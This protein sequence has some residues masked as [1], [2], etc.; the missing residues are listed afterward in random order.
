MSVTGAGAADHH[1][2]DSVIVFFANLGSIV[3]QIVTQSVEPGHIDSEIGNFQ[4]ILHF[5]RIGIVNV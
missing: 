3:K 2:L 5:F 4:E 1:I